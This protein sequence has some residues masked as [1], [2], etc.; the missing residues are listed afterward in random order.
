MVLNESFEDWFGR[1]AGLPAGG[2]AHPWQVELAGRQEL[3]DHSIRIPTGF[4]KTLGALGAWL[5]NRVQRRDPN[6]PRRLVWCL[7]M[8]VLVEQT[9]AE[10]RAALGRV[11]LLQD[12]GDGH[13]S[14]VG[15]HRLMGGV[16]AGEWLL[17]PEREAVLVGTQD[18]LLSRAM[19]RGYG[20][21]R[22]RWPME[23]GLLNQD[24]L[25]VMDEVQL[26]DVGLATSVQLQ[27]FRRE[28]ER[29][30]KALRPARTWWMSA[31][32]QPAW[33]AKS[34][35]AESLIPGR[36]QSR[37][38][39]AARRGPLWEGVR[40]PV[41]LRAVASP[42]VLADIAAEAHKDLGRGRD[43]PTL[44]VLNTVRDAIS[45]FR[46]LQARSDLPGAELR[47]VHSRFRGA[48][49]ARWR[50]DFLHRGACAPGAERII[51]ATQVVE[52]G[53]DI[54][55]ALLVTQLA[56][57]ASLV[58][59]FGRAAR[60]G[61]SARIVVADHLPLDS[62]LTPDALRARRE[63]AALPYTLDELEAAR[64]ALALLDDVAPRHLEAFEDA[65]P[66]MLDALYPYVPRHMLLRHEVDELFDTAADLS[67]AD[68]DISRFIRS[69]DERDLSVFWAAIARGEVPAPSLRPDRD[70]LCAV[71][72][73]DA[74]EWLCG[75][76][77][78]D[79]RAPRLAAGRRAWVWDYLA[80]AWRFAQ[81]RDLFPGQTVLVA[82]DTGGYDERLGWTPDNRTP[83]RAVDAVAPR[84]EDQADA[85]EDDESLSAIPAWQTIATH[86]AQV[87]REATSAAHGIGEGYQRIVHL[88]GRWHDA[89][90][91]LPPFQRSISAGDRPARGDLAKAP[92]AAWLP[93][94]RMYPDPPAAPRRGFRHELASTLAL[95]DVLVRHAPDHPALLG[96][97]RELLAATGAPAAAASPSGVD[98]TPIE[99]EVISLGADDFDLLA[100]LV[101]A[102]HGK[103]RV[104]WHA[105][106]ADQDAGDSVLRLRGVRDGEILPA[107][108]LMAEDGSYQALPPR[109]LRL[110]AAS[111]GLN[112]VTGRGWTERVLGLLRVH[113]PFALAYLE[114]LLRA[115]DRRASS[116]PL[117]DPLL[118]AENPAHG[119]EA[120]HRELAPAEPSGASAPTLAAH[121]AQRGA[122]HGLRGRAGEPA[123]AG[124]GTRPPSHA[125]RHLET[126]RGILSYADLAPLLAQRA[127]A[128]ER[129]I[130]CGRFDDEPIDDALIQ[131]L[132]TDLCGELVPDIAGWRRKD[133]MV[134]VHEPPPHFR[135]PLAMREYARDL[136]ARLEHLDERPDLL[137]ELL[138][139]AEGRLL[140]IHPFADFNGR[141]TRLFLRLLLRRLDLP[142]VDLVPAPRQTRS[143]LDAL[144]AGDRADWGPLAEV[145]RERFAADGEGL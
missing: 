97:W 19:N 80:G 68:V 42:D 125:T 144:A 89:G 12:A 8:R 10:I 28:D 3:A 7:P 91:A 114:A 30:G 128:I 58:Q 62:A 115:A 26:M 50:E 34:P 5:W 77:T 110:D 76:E 96:P 9:D 33:L 11:G 112:P 18:M 111:A 57:W 104:A 109:R 137:P 106:P 38:E 85:S 43:G 55:A 139:F 132:H 90:K 65:H 75:K 121:S 136:A 126:V 107:M 1:L 79:R 74:R 123:G 70:A 116:A 66:R 81:R 119:L 131:R 73:L 142:A 117:A 83:V 15:V 40:K 100:Y 141:A 134:G 49:R 92:P 35:E 48:D 95:F 52:A 88:A 120:S 127:A 99:R 118:D 21:F 53:V 41:D 44:L 2:R 133:V 4:G 23:F 102:H 25:W 36:R 143:Y 130:E 87:G 31:T 46:A 98:P 94:R 108:V 20:S 47:L 13:M 145:W 135:V 113:G 105:S 78:K 22:A 27:A 93:P 129:D 16:A 6:W 24:C 32:L 86:G 51:V 84:A 72:F 71:P 59:R 61:G 122:E 45:V 103:V 14:G 82:S 63:R 37:V 140:S 29:A 60:W 17:H 64:E 54:S 39:P 124:G 67:G 69:G 138:A 56:P 101:C